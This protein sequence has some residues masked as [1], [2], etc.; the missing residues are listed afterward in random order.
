MIFLNSDL[1]KNLHLEID[2]LKVYNQKDCV[3]KRNNFW[4]SFH[5]DMFNNEIDTQLHT[6]YI[7][8]NSRIEYEA[9]Q[10]L[11]NDY[12]KLLKLYLEIEE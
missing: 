3:N 4:N 9:A 2:R 10:R 7:K 8:T 5:S 12:L 1:E 6:N 11:T